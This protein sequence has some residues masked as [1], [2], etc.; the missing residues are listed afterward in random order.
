MIQVLSSLYLAAVTGLALY[1]LLGLLT[2]YLY[3]R[4]R[5]QTFPIPP[6]CLEDLPPVTVQLPVY[7]ERF[8]IQRLI[9][10]AV[11]LDYPNDRL[12]IQVIDDSGDETT[13]IAGKL[14]TYY[15]QAGKNISLRH[16]SNRAGYKAGALAAALEV[17]TG[18]FIAIFDADFQPSP[19][20]LRQIIPYFLAKPTL[21]MVQ[22]RWGHLN[23]ADSPLTAA[24]A[25]ALD[26]HFAI[27]QIVRHRAK[28]SRNSMDPVV[29]G[30]AAVSSKPEDGSLIQFAKIFV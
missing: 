18:E 16:R 8:V 15:Q 12:Q 9:E 27:E 30:G 1:G 10:A 3:W 2:L 29:C 19:D 13:Q 23:D 6:S 20:Y 22:A 11:A 4:H 26:K 28:L 5:H 17:A 21:G 7:N 14:V 24:Q 25:I